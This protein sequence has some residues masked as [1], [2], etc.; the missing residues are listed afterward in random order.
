MLPF[1]DTLLNDK[2]PLVFPIPRI[3]AP[4]GWRFSFPPKF[5]NILSENKEL[6]ALI[7]DDGSITGATLMQMI[8]S[9]AFLSLKS[10][11]VISIFGRL[12]DFQKEL[13]SR[14]KSIRVK[15]RVQSL[16]GRSCAVFENDILQVPIAVF[17]SF[18]F[19]FYYFNIAA[20]KLAALSGC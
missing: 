2:F 9:V 18:N 14:V 11:D 5:M 12:E 4:K 17:Q 19:L 7:I 13:F 1:T 6:S 16:Q 8:D 3:M 15:N 10:I 20:F